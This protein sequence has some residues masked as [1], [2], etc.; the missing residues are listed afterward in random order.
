MSN[1]QHA[2]ASARRLTAE[3]RFDWCCGMTPRT[4]RWMRSRRGRA[5]RG[6]VPAG[7]ATSAKRG[8]QQRTAEPRTAHC[9]SSSWL[10]ARLQGCGRPCGMDMDE[11]Y[12]IISARPVRRQL[13]RNLQRTASAAAAAATGC[14]LKSPVCPIKT[15]CVYLLSLVMPACGACIAAGKAVSI[16]ERY[17]AQT[18]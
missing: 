13:P 11:N 10:N 18:I 5:N 6:A 15:P 7:G 1:T 17:S 2:T 8:P 16:S 4:P 3:I 9:T 12:E 14:L